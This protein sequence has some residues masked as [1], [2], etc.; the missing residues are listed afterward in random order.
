MLR[1]LHECHCGKIIRSAMGQQ[2]MEQRTVTTGNRHRRTRTITANKNSAAQA[3]QR[4]AVMV[5]TLNGH[6][7]SSLRRFAFW[8]QCRIRYNVITLI[9]RCLRCRRTPPPIE[10]GLAIGNGAHTLRSMPSGRN[11]VAILFHCRHN[12]SLRYCRFMMRRV[13][14]PASRRR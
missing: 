6:T 2:R 1:R 11:S 12:A 3:M 8:S 13:D 14:T 4:I 9:L 10:V 7:S 5:I